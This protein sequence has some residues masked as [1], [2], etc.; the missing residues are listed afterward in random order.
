MPVIKGLGPAANRSGEK[1]L[2]IARNLAIR[3]QPCRE[4]LQH[5]PDLVAQPVLR[6]GRRF[7]WN[8][9]RGGH[10]KEPTNAARRD[11]AGTT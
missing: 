6:R 2:V 4:P 10:D 1:R 3:F 8:F 11:L 5:A 9:E 7:F